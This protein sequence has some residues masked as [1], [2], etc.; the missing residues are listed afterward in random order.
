[1]G[2]QFRRHKTRYPGVY[3]IESERAYNG[4]S[5]RIY[6]IRYRRPGYRETEEKVGRSVSE[7]MTAA[8]ANAIRAERLAGNRPTN[9]ERRREAAAQW[10]IKRL[11]EAYEESSAGKSIKTDKSRYSLHVGPVLGKK[12]PGDLSLLDLDRLRV[13]MKKKGYATQT[14]RHALALVVRLTRWGMER[15]LCKPLSFAPRLPKVD[16]QKTEDLSYDQIKILIEVL[17]EHRGLTRYR[18]AADM[19]YLALFTGMRRGEIAGLRWEDVDLGRGFVRIRDPKSGRSVTNPINRTAT[20]ILKERK[21]K[22]E[23][24]FPGK[25]GGPVGDAKN[26]MRAIRKAA[27]LPEGFRYMHGLRHVYASTLADVGTPGRAMQALL[28]HQDSKMTNRYTHPRDEAMRRA[29][30]ALDDAYRDGDEEG[31]KVIQIGDN[32]T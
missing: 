7:K 29:V 20:R 10:T 3:W 28:N 15:E 24:V 23:Y 19:M 18:D 31:G 32:R 27:G 2:R 9:Q 12:T 21:S 25:D 17:D 14:I 8:A 13:G 5:E 16:N 6:Y 30:D 26:A 11:W 1:M 4:K 22:S